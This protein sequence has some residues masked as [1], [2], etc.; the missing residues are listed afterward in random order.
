MMLT[1]VVFEC[2]MAVMMMMV[3]VVDEGVD[4]ERVKTTE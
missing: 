4:I 3:K 1:L 2:I